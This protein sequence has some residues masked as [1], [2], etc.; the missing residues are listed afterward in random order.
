MTTMQL[1]VAIVSVIGENALPLHFSV[2]DVKTMSAADPLAYITLAFTRS[3]LQLLCILGPLLLFALLLH[4]TAALIR[5]RAALLCG[6]QLH[7]WLTFPGVVVHELGH[8]FFCLVFGHKI[9]AISLFR[10]GADGV[11]GYVKHS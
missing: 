11:L 7:L 1:G 3:G 9:V 8:A 2:A 5:Q 10:P 4:T 6:P